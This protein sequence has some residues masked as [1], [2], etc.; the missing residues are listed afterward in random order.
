[1]TAIVAPSTTTANFEQILSLC[2]CLVPTNANFSRTGAT[3]TFASDLGIIA[4]LSFITLQTSNVPLMQRAYGLL[5]RAPGREGMWDS[6]DALLA[7]GEA[8]MSATQ[9]ANYQ[10][11]TMPLAAPCPQKNELVWDEIQERL[12]AEPFAQSP[13]QDLSIFE[14]LE[15]GGPLIH[16]PPLDF[17][18]AVPQ[19]QF[20]VESNPTSESFCG[21]EYGSEPNEGSFGP[22]FIVDDSVIEYP[23]V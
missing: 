12:H 7:A 2:E 4:P 17:G 5:T 20:S 3:L 9:F 22:P 15:P 6:D 14:S 23:S 8:I 18:C 21:S 19:R 11:P 10:Y 16:S 13:E 1:M